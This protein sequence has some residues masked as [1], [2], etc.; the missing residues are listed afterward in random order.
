MAARDVGHLT[1][2]PTSLKDI[3]YSCSRCPT[4]RYSVAKGW[5][6]LSYA[7]KWR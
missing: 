6:A 7:V 1:A 2:T 5:T 4:M 3:R